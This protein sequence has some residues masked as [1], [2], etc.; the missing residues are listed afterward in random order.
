MQQN[1]KLLEREI[2]N[3]NEKPT[4]KWKNFKISLAKTFSKTSSHFFSF[5]FE[6][7]L[8]L[9]R[10]VFLFKFFSNASVKSMPV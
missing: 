5:G 3:T 6:I 1:K 10:E 9:S 8:S 7:C 4:S 2:I